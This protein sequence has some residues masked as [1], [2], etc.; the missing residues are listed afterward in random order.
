M[1]R[2][3]APNMQR[4]TASNLAA[5]RSEHAAANRSEH[6][7]GDPLLPRAHTIIITQRLRRAVQAAWLVSAESGRKTHSQGGDERN[8]PI[9]KAEGV[10]RNRRPPQAAASEHL[11]FVGEHRD[12][13]GH[14]R[15][16]RVLLLERV[17]SLC[18]ETVGSTSCIS[19]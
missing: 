15:Q 10:A 11:P 8:T 9:A 1:Q 16:A 12:L 2:R 19:L 7:S 14:G 5:S 18:V 13:L 4:R 6:A 3:T 17:A